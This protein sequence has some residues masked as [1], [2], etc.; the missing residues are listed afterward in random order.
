[1]VGG[2]EKSGNLCSFRI[3]N[4]P[5]YKS[6]KSWCHHSETTVE[7][8]FNTHIEAKAKHFDDLKFGLNKFL[9]KD[10]V[11]KPNFDS[12]LDLKIKWVKTQPIDIIEQIMDDSYRIH[13]MCKA[14]LDSENPK[15]FDM[16]YVTAWRK[17][18]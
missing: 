16:D 11:P 10:Y 4:L 2:L 13:I 15:T 12:N 7:N 9:D 17:Y 1:M 18:K 8:E 6:F 5:A 3:R 14:I